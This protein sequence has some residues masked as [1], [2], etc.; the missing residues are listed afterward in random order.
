MNTKTTLQLFSVLSVLIS[1]CALLESATGHVAFTICTVAC[2]F[3]VLGFLGYAR[4]RESGLGDRS[5]A[6]SPHYIAFIFGSLGL[7]VAFVFFRAFVR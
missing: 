2:S 5:E 4:F 1:L 6:L 7:W 3:L